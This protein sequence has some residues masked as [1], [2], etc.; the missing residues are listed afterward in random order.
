MAPVLA[1]LI[2]GAYGQF[3]GQLPSR[4]HGGRR[5]SRPSPTAQVY[6]AAASVDFQAACLRPVATAA[7]TPTLA[8]EAAPVPRAPQPP[9]NPPEEPADLIAA[10]SAGYRD[11]GGPPEYLDHL[12]NDVIPCEWGWEPWYP[13]NGYLTRAQFDPGSWENAGGGDYTDEYTVGA[14]VGRWVR[15]VDPG[16]SGGWPWCWWIGASQ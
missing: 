1:V 11:A 5:D 14:N 13:G 3:S 2:G 8:P 10:F 16:G 7:P 4:L 12:I 15:M 9:A 6:S